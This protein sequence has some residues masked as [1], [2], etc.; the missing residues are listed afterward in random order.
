MG[1]FGGFGELG[2]NGG[3]VTGSLLHET[4]TD[5]ITTRKQIITAWNFFIF[6]IFKFRTQ[7]CINKNFRSSRIKKTFTSEI[8]SKANWVKRRIPLPNGRF[9]RQWLSVMFQLSNQ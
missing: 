1:G 6:L 9:F 5:N 4:K 2:L 3:S 8:Q 7:Y